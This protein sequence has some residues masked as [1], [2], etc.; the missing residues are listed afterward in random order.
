M[1][2]LRHD[3]RLHKLLLANTFSSMGSGITM[4]AIPWL[5]LTKEGGGILLGYMTL[6][7]TI[8][9]FVVTPYVGVI[10]DQLS[11]KKLLIIGELLGFSV[12]SF[13]IILGFM[14]VEYQ[15]WHLSVLLIS[16]GFYYNLFYPTIFAFNQEIFDKSQYKA[17]NGI[18][19][20]QGQLAAVLAGGIAAFL[21]PLIN[22]KWILVLDAATYLIAIGLFLTIPYKKKV[23]FARVTE[24]FF[25]KLT[26]G[27]RFMK[28]QPRLFFF[29]LASFIPFIVVMVTNYVFPI[30]IDTILAAD[31]SVYGMKS[32]VYGIGAALAG[33]ILP[34]LLTRIGNE[35]AIVWLMFVFMIAVVGYIFFQHVLIFYLLTVIFAFGAAGTRVARNS[36]MMEVV[37]NDKMGRVDSLFRVIGLSIR[38]V[39]LATFTQ[40]I[41]NANIMVSFHILSVM[42]VGSLITILL[43][44]KVV[45]VRVINEYQAKAL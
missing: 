34:I 31:V 32:M 16:G 38:M 24:S 14:G 33:L 18:M 21:L 11:R 19:E 12:I 9:M 36:L 13:F 22:F 27:Y 30:Y 26:E 37:P 4:I 25:F 6:L 17:L 41:A 40:I 10:I 7:S 5:F 28:Q 35:R 42:L 45:R 23:S 1:K 15:T 3:T 29:L 43:T 44:Y 20:V 39:L 8:L 2:S